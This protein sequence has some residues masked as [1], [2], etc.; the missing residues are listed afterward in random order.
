MQSICICG[1]PEKKHL[2]LEELNYIKNIKMTEQIVHDI[3]RE[4]LKD[5]DI[6]GMSPC[7][8][9]RPDNLKALELEAFKREVADA[10]STMPKKD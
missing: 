7:L 10:N 3:L 5:M 4:Y 2:N 9:F 6:L 8:V 1:F